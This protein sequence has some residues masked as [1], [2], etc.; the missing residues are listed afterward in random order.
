MNWSASWAMHF[1]RLVATDQS[2]NTRVPHRMIVSYNFYYARPGNAA[3]VLQQRIRASDVR[4]QLGLPRGRIISKIK[5]DDDWPDVIWRLDFAD[6]AAQD[7][8][9][10]ARAASAEFE[11]IRHGMRQLY[12]RFER[13][14]YAPFNKDSPPSKGGPQRS[15]MLYGIYCDAAVS[16]AARAVLDTTPAVAYLS[17][18]TDIPNILCETGSD[19][20]PQAMLEG[21]RH[22]PLRVERSLWRIED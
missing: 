4:T 15:M 21:W 13:P 10:K 1:V 17:G 20:L 2:G 8:D 9:M 6:M 18:A 11:A 12:R 19:G 16:A 5:G 7:A 22:L 3:A 14:L